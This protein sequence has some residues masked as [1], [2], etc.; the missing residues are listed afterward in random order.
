MSQF[1]EMQFLPP[2]LQTLVDRE[3]GPDE[4]LVWVG[5]PLPAFFTGASIFPFLFAI[6]WTAFAVSW[7]G[8]AI[9]MGAPLGF[10]LFGVPFVLIGLAM[11]CSPI[12]L[13]RC[14]KNTVY[15]I[16]DKRALIFVGTFFSTNIKS[17]YPDD[18]D[19][20]QRKEKANGTGSVFF[21]EPNMAQQAPGT[22]FL[23]G[24]FFNISQAKE[25]ERLLRNLAAQ[26]AKEE[27]QEAQTLE[28]LADPPVLQAIGPAPRDL[29]L[30]VT[31]YLRL[32]SSSGSFFGWFF[33]GFGFMFALIAVSMIGLDD[34]IPRV[35]SDAGKGKIIRIEATDFHI[36]DRK[37]FAYHF[38]TNDKINGISYGYEGKYQ[39][40]QEVPLEKSGSRCRVR[41]LTLTQGGWVFPLIFIGAGSLFGIIGLCFPICSWFSGGKAAQLLRG[42]D[43]TK[44]R[45]LGMNST[46]MQVN[47]R[48]VMKVDFEYQVNGETYTASARALE[49][50]RLTDAD[51]Q[52]V[53]YDPMQPDKSV[54][55][56]GLPQ[57][58][59][60]DEMTGRF[61]VN[62]LRCVIPL[63]AAAVVCGE[64]IAIVVMVVLAI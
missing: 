31:L 6:P 27:E 33:A 55:L 19:E 44:A 10:A 38:E 42:G 52:V 43:T 46:N 7:M 12:Y 17:F 49:T 13:R 62:P 2:T 40:D 23:T 39:V 41:G 25:V 21:G 56:N 64:I 15:A 35:W 60:L 58:I 9:G 14:M 18:L 20:L 3:L 45:F 32:C 61:W 30:A 48:S 22:A 5:Q 16:T 4:N 53:F 34:T 29:P 37:V 54:V 51:C 47:G 8:G 57:G 63:L 50:S 28:Q 59:R 36:N 26:A 1:Y 11:L 24:G